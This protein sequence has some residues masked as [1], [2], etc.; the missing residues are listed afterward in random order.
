M[1]NADAGL[2]EDGLMT[3]SEASAFTRLS[4]SE[5]Y[6]RMDRGDLAYC[7]LGKRRL[8]PRIALVEM[9]RQG[10]IVRQPA[11]APV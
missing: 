11:M 6:A 5:L 7:K 1:A 10:L 8:I 3:I 9:A 2:V 4:R